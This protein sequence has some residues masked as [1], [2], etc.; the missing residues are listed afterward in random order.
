VTFNVTIPAGAH[1]ND[2]QFSV[3]L[4]DLTVNSGASLTGFTGTDTVVRNN[5]TNHG[6]GNFGGTVQGNFINDAVSANGDVANVS[7]N[8]KIQGQLQNT[9]ELLVTGT[10]ENQAATSNSGMVIF[11]SGGA[12]HQV[13]AFTNDGTVQLADA[14]SQI[15]GTGVVTNNGTFQ[16]TG[17]SILTGSTV[18]NTSSNFTISGSTANKNI[19]GG[20]LNNTGTIRQSG[21]STLTFY[22]NGTLNNQS[23]G[24]YDLQDDSHLKPLFGGEPATIINAGTIRKSGGTGTST[25]GVDTSNSGTLA[26]DAGVLSFTGA[27]SLSSSSKL[28][29]QLRGLT[30]AVNYGKLNKSG[31]LAADGALQV[32]LGSGFAPALNN[33]FDLLDWGSLSGTFSAV[34][35]PALASGLRWDTSQLYTSGVV[36]VGVGLPGDFN[37]NGVVDAPDYVTWRKGL[38]TTYTQSDYDIWRTHFG[39]TAGGGAGAIANAAVPEPAT[40]V[41]LMVVAAGWCL[42]RGGPA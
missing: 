9:G 19:G 32:T 23:G 33:T 10:L 25:V 12:L 21:A 4:H 3:A 18:S 34:Q 35:L 29:F 42:R 5:I 22:S 16:W 7:G 37:Q 28:A 26:V 6:S 13:A 39:Q 40:L 30:P 1:V 24:V 27:L 11:N 20:T 17:G 36:S 38:G 14:S 2:D 41:L 31:A 15:N 8:L